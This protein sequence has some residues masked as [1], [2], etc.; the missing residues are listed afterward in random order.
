MKN[1]ESLDVSTALCFISTIQRLWP[2]VERACCFLPLL[3]SG[4]QSLLSKVYQLA[5]I[6]TVDLEV[7]G[8]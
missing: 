5:H 4:Q 7:G 6:F 8:R 3:A 2:S 1:L